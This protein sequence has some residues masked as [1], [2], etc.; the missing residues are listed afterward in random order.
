MKA[1][2]EKSKKEELTLYGFLSENILFSFSYTDNEER[3]EKWIKVTLPEK[4]TIDKLIISGPYDI[5]KISFTFD[6]KINVNESQ[7]LN[8]YNHKKKEI[9]VKNNN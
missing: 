9:L 2:D 3:K 4:I 1:H 5:D 6:C 8:M 7:I